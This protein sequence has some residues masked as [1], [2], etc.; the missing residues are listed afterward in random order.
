MSNRYCAI[1][2]ITVLSVVVQPVLAQK[3][4]I[5]LRPDFYMDQTSFYRS[6]STINHRAEV[7][8]LD[9]TNPVTIDT[10]SGM[11]LRVVKLHP[12]GGADIEWTLRFITITSSEILPGMTTKLDYDSREPGTE[13]SPLA[14][15]VADLI[16]NP[17]TITVDATGKVL[18]FHRQASSGPSGMPGDLLRGF[19]S[20]SLFEQLPFF[21]TANAPSPAR[22]QAHWK[23]DTSIR[24]PMGVGSFDL[25]SS[26]K[27][28]K[29]KKKQQQATIAMTGTVTQGPD[30][31][32]VAMPAPANALVIHQ[33]NYSGSMVWD[34]YLGQLI[35][36]ESKM[37]LNLTMDTVLGRMKI[38][39]KIISSVER[40]LIPQ[41]AKAP[42]PEKQ[43]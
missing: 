39:Q 21:V 36:A 27:I 10:E 31:S 18:G 20:E 28:E 24:L 23:Q 19:F 25:H 42:Q 3:K 34:T 30:S 15:I 35:G 26:F 1:F 7:E 13:N 14:P 9:L 2:A 16:R 12:E 5:N 33:S 29:F 40:M 43:E 11:K 41:P 37:F 22:R 4:G 8:G 6:R 17:I 38:H 32:G